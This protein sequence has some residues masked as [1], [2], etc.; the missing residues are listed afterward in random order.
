MRAWWR[1]WVWVPRRERWV[2]HVPILT[3]YADLVFREHYIDSIR[4]QIHAPCLLLR[5][6]DADL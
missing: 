1:R 6:L 2:F 3:A 5:R 4:E